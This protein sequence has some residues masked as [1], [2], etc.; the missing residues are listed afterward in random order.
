MIIKNCISCQARLIKNQHTLEYVPFGWKE[1]IFGPI[2]NTFDLYS[3]PECDEKGNWVSFSYFKESILWTFYYEQIPG[4]H[5]FNNY[6]GNSCKIKSVNENH[7]IVG[8]EI[9]LSTCLNLDLSDIE[10]IK[11]TVGAYVT[12]A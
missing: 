3:C 12:F 2:P 11:K 7:E 1:D 5:I 10:S 9:A 6:I 8:I 4:L